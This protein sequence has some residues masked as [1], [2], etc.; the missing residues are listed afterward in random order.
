MSPSVR[1]ASIWSHRSA[2]GTAHRRASSG[3]TDELADRAEITVVGVMGTL[4]PHT[5]RGPLE[6][7]A[8]GTL[9]VPVA[10]IQALV[11]AAPPLN[12]FGVLEL[13][14]NEVTVP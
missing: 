6:H 1:P 12:A 4:T 11:D 9:T 14:K 5:G 7:V 8:V 3:V 10:T 2:I 13:R